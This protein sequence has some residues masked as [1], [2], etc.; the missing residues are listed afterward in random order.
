VFENRVLK[1]IFGAERDE[2]TGGW[3]KLYN[4]LHNLYFL[5][6]IVRTIKDEMVGECSMYGGD[7]KCIQNVGWK[8]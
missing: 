6:N 4:E 2:M 3:T 1:R 5:P 8:A 7:K